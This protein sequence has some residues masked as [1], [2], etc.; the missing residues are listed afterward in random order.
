VNAYRGV[1]SAKVFLRPRDTSLEYQGIISIALTTAT[2]VKIG[3][4]PTLAKADIGD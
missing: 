2:L 3:G 1:H 4:Y